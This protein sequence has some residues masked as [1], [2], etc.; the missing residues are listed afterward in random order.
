MEISL[1]PKL[2]ANSNKEDS[3]AWL[4]E[5]SAFVAI[6][7]KPEELNEKG[8]KFVKYAVSGSKLALTFDGNTTYNSAMEKIKKQFAVQSQSAM[9]LNDFFSLKW[10]DCDLN[11]A[12][13]VLRLKGIVTFIDNA[14]AKEQL[15]VQ[16]CLEQFRSEFRIILKTKNL[17]TTPYLDDIMV[18]TTTV[19]ENLKLLRRVFERLRDAKF[20]LKPKKCKFLADHANY[21]GFV[22]KNKTVYPEATKIEAIKNADFPTSVKALQRFLGL[23]NFLSRFVSKYADLCSPLTLIQNMPPNK[24]KCY[25]EIHKGALHQCFENVKNAICSSSSLNLPNFS[26]KFFLNVVASDDAIGGVLYQNRGAIA[27]YSR[28]LTKAEQNYSTIDKEFLALFSSIRR[29]HPYL[30]GVQFEAYTDHKPLIQFLKHQMHSGRQ[31]RWFLMLQQYHYNLNYIKGTENKAADCLSRLNCCSTNLASDSIHSLV[32][33]SQKDSNIVQNCINFLQGKESLLS[34]DNLSNAVKKCKMLNLKTFSVCQ[35]YLYHDGRLVVAS[36]AEDSTITSFHAC[37]HFS[38]NKRRE[39]FLEKYWL[40]KLRNKIKNIVDNCSC[41]VQKSYGHNPRALKFPRQ[42]I[43]NFEV[44]CLDLVSMP[45]SRGFRYLLTIIDIKS[46]LLA[47]ISLS[48]FSATTI[49]NEP[50]FATPLADF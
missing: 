36:E 35:G 44:I 34:S 4:S 12:Q 41:K 29:F 40:P 3:D 48:N 9:P 15:I 46:Q 16:H 42:S 33:K 26:E 37:G 18:P 47:A 7:L 14:A 43:Q 21:L 11:F 49:A 6:V 19:E 45:F 39:L 22:I 28:K 20:K 30:Y 17:A 23:T 50:V 2:K 5:F 8:L 27:F 10:I 25:I 32:M 38:T 1:L 24:Y 13:Y 31:Q